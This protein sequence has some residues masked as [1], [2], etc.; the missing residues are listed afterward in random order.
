MVSI[1]THAHL[2]A[3]R[4]LSFCFYCGETFLPD[5]ARDFDHV[6]ASAVFAKADRAPLKLP[7]HVQCNGAHSEADAK[8]GQL[9]GLLRNEVPGHPRNR[10]LAF[11]TDPGAS[12]GAVLNVPLDAMARRWLR[13][14]HAALYRQPLPSGARYAITLPLPRGMMENGRPNIEPPR[15]PQHRLFVETIKNCRA[16]ANIDRLIANKGK[17]TYECVWAPDDGGRFW[18]CIFALNIYDWR[19]LAPTNMG[20]RCGCAGCYTVSADQVPEHGTRLK[21]FAI[22]VPNFDPDDP[23]GQ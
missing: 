11:Y 4:R 10:K 22:R 21:P 2:Q 6:P 23:F 1:T 17:L 20:E 9:I 18:H 7:A 16:H 14:F 19:D 5:D 15:L 3:A 12:L 13:G 8:V